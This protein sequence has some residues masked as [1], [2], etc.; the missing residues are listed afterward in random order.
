MKFYQLS[1]GELLA[2]P[3]HINNFEGAS[4]ARILSQEEFEKLSDP[5]LQPSTYVDMRRSAYPLLEQLA[6]ALWHSRQGNPG[7]LKQY[8]AACRAVKEKYPKPE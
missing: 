6:D 4:Q 7:P 8:D 5:K 2:A 3:E 1:N